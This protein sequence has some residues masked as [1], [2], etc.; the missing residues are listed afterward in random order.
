MSAFQHMSASIS[1]NDGHFLVNV[2]I[3]RQSCSY[4]DT[5]LVNVIPP[6]LFVFVLYTGHMLL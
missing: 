6:H 4:N 5:R 1:A 2:D 3:P